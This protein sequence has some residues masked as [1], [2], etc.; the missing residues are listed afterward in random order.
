MG[1]SDEE[2]GRHDISL[3]VGLVLEDATVGQ[4]GMTAGDELNT[5]SMLS[6]LK[7]LLRPFDREDCALKV[8]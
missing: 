3:E 7:G 6:L 4:P 2:E 1:W 5:Y 8:L